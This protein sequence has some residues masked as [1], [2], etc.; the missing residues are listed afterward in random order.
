[1]FLVENQN[2]DAGRLY[3]VRVCKTRK[4]PME[5]VVLSSF[6]TSRSSFGLVFLGAPGELPFDTDRVDI[7]RGLKKLSC[8]D[9]LRHIGMSNDFIHGWVLRRS[10][11]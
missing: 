1:M 2:V 5:M 9:F 11:L 4:R 10:S 8:L 7:V 3:I 6:T